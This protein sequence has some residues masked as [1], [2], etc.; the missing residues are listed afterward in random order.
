MA[1]VS[2][3]TADLRINR[4]AMMIAAH[5]EAKASVAAAA[6]RGKV[7]RYKIALRDALMGIWISAK[8]QREFAL[9]DAELA[10]MPAAQAQAVSSL[11]SE[12][13]FARTIDSLPAHLAAMAS[14][15]A[16]AAALGVSL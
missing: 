12:V 6:K 11:R 3:L 16:R 7:R 15:S 14:V 10:A 1:Q 13:M 5:A 4:S 8:T 2:Y 9:R